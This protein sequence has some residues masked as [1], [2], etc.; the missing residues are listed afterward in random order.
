MDGEI[1]LDTSHE[2]FAGFPDS[3]RLKDELYWK[4]RKGERGK[5]TVLGETGTPG[6]A[7]A[8]NAA[9][10]AAD[11]QWPVF[12]TVE[13]PAVDGG[14]EGR[15]FCSVVGHI[16]TMYDEPYFRTILLRGISWCIREPFAPFEVLVKDAEKIHGP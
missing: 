12:W 8:Q 5:I 3:F 6:K 14:K 4:L 2:I 16:D 11:E 9:K 1:K 15:V 10:D 7:K 13:H